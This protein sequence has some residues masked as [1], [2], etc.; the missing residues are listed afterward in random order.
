MSI[1]NTFKNRDDNWNDKKM[2]ND[3]RKMPKNIYSG[4][5]DGRVSTHIKRF[6]WTHYVFKYK[7]F[8][9]L[10][11]LAHWVM[12]KSIVKKIPKESYNQNIIIFDQAFEEAL[13]KW[14]LLNQRNSGPRDKRA[15]KSQLLK[16]YRGHQQLRDLKE[17]V[18]SMM[19]YDHDRDW[20]TELR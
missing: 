4:L 11:K 19:L 12:R 1:F 6:H 13:K 8:V 18:N 20:E 16:R 7:F 9:P 2:R 3:N 15:S 17:I 14:I 10:V 5:D